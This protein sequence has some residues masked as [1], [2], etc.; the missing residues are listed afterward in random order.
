[1]S[2]GCTFLNKNSDKR[3]TRMTVCHVERKRKGSCRA[4]LKNT[5]LRVREVGFG[6]WTIFTGSWGK[7]TEGGAIA[8]LHIYLDDLLPHSLG[9]PPFGGAK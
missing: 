1:V 3:K 7:L 8:E 4:P 5:D 6:R 2:R 9:R